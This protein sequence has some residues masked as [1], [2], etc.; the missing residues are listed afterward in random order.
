[1]E[2]RCCP[3]RPMFKVVMPPTASGHHC[4]DSRKALESAGAQVYPLAADTDC[5]LSSGSPVGVSG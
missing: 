3:A 1:M 4:R 2:A 5:A